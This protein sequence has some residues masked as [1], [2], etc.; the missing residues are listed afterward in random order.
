MMVCSKNV[1]EKTLHSLKKIIRNFKW[2]YRTSGCL[3]IQMY[4]KGGVSLFGGNLTCTNMMWVYSNDS[5]WK[6]WN[7]S[8]FWKIVCKYGGR[9]SHSDYSYFHGIGN[10]GHYEVNFCQNEVWNM[11]KSRATKGKQHLGILDLLKT[12]CAGWL[13]RRWRQYCNSN[14]W[15]TTLF[16][17]SVMYT[18]HIGIC[19]SNSFGSK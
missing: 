5:E 9:Y 13:Y 15:T 14:K 8:N 18:I 7:I 1:E 3:K 19:S 6:F 2:M 12:V 4:F 16:I 10:M 11:R 17:L